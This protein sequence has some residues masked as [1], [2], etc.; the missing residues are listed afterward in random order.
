M[1]I[2]R[3]KQQVEK[4]GEGGKE[5]RRERKLGGKERNREIGKERNGE[6]GKERNREIGKEG[7]RKGG[8]E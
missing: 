6:I 4:G 3:K 2:Y 7:R 5:V 1:Q 8:N